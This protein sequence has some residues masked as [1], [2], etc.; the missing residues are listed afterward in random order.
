MRLIAGFDA[1]ATAVMAEAYDKACVGKPAKRREG[2]GPLNAVS[3]SIDLK[4]QPFDDRRPE[5]NVG[6]E[7]SPEFLGV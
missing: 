6:C 1:E 4:A 5:S 3:C 7:G 2:F